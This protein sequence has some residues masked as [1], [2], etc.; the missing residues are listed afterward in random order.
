M[1]KKTIG[2]IIKRLPHES[3]QYA[4]RD[5]TLLTCSIFGETHFVPLKKLFGI[6][7]YVIF[8]YKRKDGQVMFYRSG[9][10][11][12]LFAKKVGLKCLKDINFAK[13]VADTLIEMT[14]YINKFLK[15]NNTLNKLLL[16]W[17]NFFRAYRDFFAYHQATYWASEYLTK[18]EAASKEQKQK[19]DKIV[20]VLDKAYKYNEKVVPDVEGYFI[21]LGIGD[22]IYAEINDKVLENIKKAPKRRSVLWLGRK[23]QVLSSKDADQVNKAISEDYEKYL[24][25]I[26]EVK[27]LGV[28]QGLARGRVRLITDLSQLR[29]CK[30]DDVLVTT[31]TRPQYNTFIKKVKAIVTDEGGLLCH[32]SML[33]REF[34]MPCVVGTKNATKLLKNGD[35]IEVNADKGTVRRIGGA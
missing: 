34:G 21:K 29:D 4:V 24:K 30:K 19:V 22:L 6:N 25:T 8:W 17:D 20:K 13:E 7:F 18:M 10:E 2:E 27:G 16:K 12:D 1:D 3:A 23:M 5:I 26:K 35:L 33:A 32:A 11:Y 9:S 14:D 28:S 31:M 15:E